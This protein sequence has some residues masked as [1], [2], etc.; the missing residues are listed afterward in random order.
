MLAPASKSRLETAATI[1]GLSSQE[2]SNRAVWESS[3]PYSAE[4]FGRTDR[5][6]AIGE[7]L[8]KL[9]QSWVIGAAVSPATG[10]WV[11]ERLSADER[12][13]RAEPVRPKVSRSS[14]AVWEPP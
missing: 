3:C 11:R 5:P 14:H 1:P 6:S 7:R 9:V 8:D 13:S 4:A 2:T 12:V 10:T